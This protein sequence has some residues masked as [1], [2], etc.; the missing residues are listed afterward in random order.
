MAKQLNNN[1]I[2]AILDDVKF[3]GFEIRLR[4]DGEE[5]P[6]NTVFG[7][8]NRRPYLQ[9]FC[10][11]GKDNDTGAPMPWTGRKWMLSR[12]MVKSE[13]VRTAFKVVM[14]AVEHETCE[15]FKYKGNAIYDPHMDV[16]MLAAARKWPLDTRE[17]SA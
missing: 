7:I 17:N 8:D 10:P 15:N 6:C 12:W 9:V 5:N 16:E 1:E 13:I 2:Q 4:F 3:P 11:D 14:T